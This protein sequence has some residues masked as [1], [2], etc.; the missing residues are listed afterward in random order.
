M[1][2]GGMPKAVQCWIDTQDLSAC[3]KIHHQL[4][5]AY[6]QDFSKYA[7]KF[8]IKYIDLLF[9]RM[10]MYVSNQ[11][12]YSSISQEYRKRELMPCVE[13]L[14]KAKILHQVVH[15]LGNGLPLGAEANLDKFKPIFLDVAL[16]QAILD[17]KG[18]DWILNPSQTLI[19]QGAITEAFV[20][21]ELLAYSDPSE[22]MHLYYWQRETRS[23]QA[24]IDYLLQK[25]NKIIP[26]EVKSGAGKSLKSLHL[27][28]QSHNQASSY[29][30][31]FSTHNYSTFDN[32][33]SYPLYAVAGLL[34]D[35]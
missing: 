4:I 19:N 20:G 15:T 25:N 33:Q 17:L 32:I 6:R 18:K 28:M 31:R 5:A 8:Q 13:L 7:K 16:T 2:I 35:T 29:G 10:P 27:F 23:S 34:A 26:I 12:K 24:K 9:N 14:S 1:A 30:V 21:Q 22:D 11:F 3:S